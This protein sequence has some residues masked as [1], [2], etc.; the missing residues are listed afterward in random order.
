M[1]LSVLKGTIPDLK[2]LVEKGA[3]ILPLLNGI[4]HISILQD[5]LSEAA[6][7]GGSAFII[8]TLNEKGHVIHSNKNHDLIFA[9]RSWISFW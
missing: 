9:L 3:K 7:I 4:E 5:E 6:V 2:L 8:A 1:A